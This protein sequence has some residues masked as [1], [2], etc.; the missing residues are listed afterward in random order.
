M[1]LQLATPSQL[2]RVRSNGLFGGLLP[3]SAFE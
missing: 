2:I 3:D 1:A